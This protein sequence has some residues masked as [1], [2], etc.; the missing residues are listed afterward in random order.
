MAGGGCELASTDWWISGRLSRSWDQPQPIPSLPQGAIWGCLAEPDWLAVPQRK[1]KLLPRCTSVGS[2]AN[3]I[4]QDLLCHLGERERLRVSFPLS[5][6]CMD[7]QSSY[8]PT[9]LPCGPSTC[10][11]STLQPLGC[12]SPQELP[13]TR[14]LFQSMS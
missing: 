7:L 4:S 11:T 6:S 2:S 10:R 14:H 5:I 1:A 8:H 12:C 9:V 3:S 13:R